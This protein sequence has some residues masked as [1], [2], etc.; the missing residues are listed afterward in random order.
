MNNLDYLELSSIPKGAKLH[1][2]QAVHHCDTRTLCRRLTSTGRTAMSVMA[3]SFAVGICGVQA[4]MHLR[5]SARSV[6]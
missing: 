2:T 6:L 5:D 1:V 3:A 4:D